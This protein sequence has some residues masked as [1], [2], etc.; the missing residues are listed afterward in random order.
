MT[1]ACAMPPLKRRPTVIAQQDSN[2]DEAEGLPKSSDDNASASDKSDWWADRRSIALLIILYLIQGLPMGYVFGTIPFLLNE[3]PN[4]DYSSIAL[5]SLAT[6]PYSLKLVVA[7]I[8]EAIYIPSIGRRHTWILSVQFLSGMCFI[9]GADLISRWVANGAARA[10]T[11]LFFLFMSL[12]AIQDI[13]VDAYALSLLRPGNRPYASTTQS[14]GTTAGYFLTFTGFLVLSDH[15]PSLTLA[16]SLRWSG[17]AYLVVT[18]GVYILVIEAPEPSSLP[19]PSSPSSRHSKQSPSASVVAA[20]CD[21]FRVLRLPA[22]RSLI[23]LLLIAKLPFSAY[24]SLTSLKL[25]D[26]GFPKAKLATLSLLQTPISM[27]GSVVAGRVASLYGS[28]LPYVGGFIMR[29]V[30]SLAGPLL[31]RAFSGKVTASFFVALVTMSCVYEL[32]ATSLMFVSIG[33]IFLDIADPRMAGSYLTLMNTI[34]NL[35]GSW[36]KPITLALAGRVIFGLDGYVVMSA[37]LASIAVPVGLFANRCLQ[38]LLA[39]PDTSWHATK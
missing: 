4:A 38:R 26:A 5:F 29:T 37:A 33:A 23:L 20:Y 16:S 32:A 9:A 30:I 1:D 19:L 13:A 31:V 18:A 36:H 17:V 24:E 8:V 27:A 7:P 25:L 22:V 39:L 11:P 12:T 3:S 35:G 10:L 14:I 28:R 6:F 2:Q 21:L 15:I 34:S